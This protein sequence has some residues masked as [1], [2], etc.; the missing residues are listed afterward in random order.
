MF[1]YSS[2]PPHPLKFPLVFLSSNHFKFQVSF[3][4]H[5]SF[6]GYRP[7]KLVPNR[8]Q[9][10]FPAGPSTQSTLWH[11]CADCIQALSS[12]CASEINVRISAFIW[13]FTLLL[14]FTL[15]LYVS[16]SSSTCLYTVTH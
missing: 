9:R 8:S 14:V 12:L 6:V 2:F 16:Y 5:F 1:R 10:L 7:R 4:C 11:Q 15:T 13:C 3:S